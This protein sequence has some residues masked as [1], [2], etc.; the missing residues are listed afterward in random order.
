MD[1]QIALKFQKCLE[2]IKL[3]SCKFE[4]IMRYMWNFSVSY[5]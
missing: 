1:N 3:F 2:I 4:K 5:K